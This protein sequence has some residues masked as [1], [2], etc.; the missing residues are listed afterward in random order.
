[1]SR[2]FGKVERR[3]LWV[4]EAQLEGEQLGLDELAA[5]VNEVTSAHPGS[6]W[7]ACKTLAA[8]GRIDLSKVGRE[9]LISR[10]LTAAEAKRRSER[11]L[12]AAVGQCLNAP[13]AGLCAFTD[14][15]PGLC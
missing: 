7:R 9:L 10:P 14:V 5:R 11:Q 15:M 8:V 12:V 1:M 4:V 6:V 2:G 13:M 3:I